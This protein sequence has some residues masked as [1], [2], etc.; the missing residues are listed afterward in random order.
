VR[1][2]VIADVH[3]NLPALT[4]V[5]DHLDRRGVDALLC[6]GDLVGYGPHPNECVELV[7]GRGIPCVAGNHDLMAIGR[8]DDRRCVPLG[9]RSQEWTRRELTAEARAY[10]AA[11]PARRV[12]GDVV[13]AHGSLDSAE[14]YVSSD[15]LAAGQLAQLARRHPDAIALV[16]GHTHRPRVHTAR[17]RLRRPGRRASPLP[18][19]GPWLVNPG[20]VGQSRQWELRPRARCLVLDVGRSTVELHALGYDVG[21][22]RAALRESGL[23]P[24]SVHLRPWR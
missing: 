8:L 21:A 11:L 12:I 16:L 13:L 15:E 24:G 1:I 5:L 17:G 19:G 9:R 4:A 2:G 18:P 3:A 6:A 20:S 7:A 22:C 10:L 23:P 14:E